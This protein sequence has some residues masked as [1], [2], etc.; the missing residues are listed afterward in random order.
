V[1]DQLQ[2]FKTTFKVENISLLGAP[3]NGR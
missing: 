3:L 1:Y 2:T